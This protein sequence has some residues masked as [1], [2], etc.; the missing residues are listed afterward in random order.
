L[1]LG[2][3]GRVTRVVW[4]AIVLG[5]LAALFRVMAYPLLGVVFT[6]EMVGGVERNL[7]VRSPHETYSFDLLTVAL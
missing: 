3:H 4:N 5:V 7:F 2:V 6:F 1:L